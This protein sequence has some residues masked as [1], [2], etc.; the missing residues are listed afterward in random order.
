VSTALESKAHTLQIQD[1]LQIVDSVYRVR[2]DHGILTCKQDSVRGLLA[3]RTACQACCQDTWTSTRYSR[4]HHGELTLYLVD[5][6]S[7][8]MASASTQVLSGQGCFDYSLCHRN[9]FLLTKG[10]TAPSPTKTGTTICGVLFAVRPFL[11]GRQPSN[12]ATR[13]PSA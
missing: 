3:S 10:V 5:H 11:V 9:A 4:A 8:I 1:S 2:Y 6:K 7:I 12:V 13:W